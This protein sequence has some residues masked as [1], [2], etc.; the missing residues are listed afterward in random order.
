M[1]YKI[2]IGDMAKLHNISTQT[3]RYYDNID[4]FKPKYIDKDNGYRYYDI[5]Q[6][7]QLD[8]ILFFKKMGV[9]LETIKDYFR[10]RDLNSMV[11][12]LNKEQKVI[13]DQILLLNSRK[14]SIEKWKAFINKY[15]NNDKLGVC[16]LKR[17][18]KR[19]ALYIELQKEGNII[20]FEYGIKK[21]YNKI[22]NYGHVF[23]SII[24]C[25]VDKE[26]LNKGI[27]NYWKGIALLFYD[28]FFKKD[29][30]TIENRDYAV[31]SYKGGKEQEVKYYNILMKW[32]NDNS[33]KVDGD[34][35]F[36]TIVDSAFSQ[37]KSQHINEIQIPV[38]K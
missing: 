20:E 1:K 24:C 15:E 4:V 16:S 25:V 26:H 29:F 32:I 22:G 19:S 17:L 37:I 33:F 21:L 3:L 14:K 8:A 38:R 31:I 30:I 36:L 9:P 34:G 11:D 2:S 18:E 10:N 23:N 12:I 13:E 7:A 5:E 6:F 27:Y 28:N 35:L